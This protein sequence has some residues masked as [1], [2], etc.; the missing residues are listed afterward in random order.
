MEGKKEHLGYLY[1]L[2]YFRSGGSCC[3]LRRLKINAS[4]QSILNGEIKTFRSGWLWK[5][6]DRSE[7]YKTKQKLLD[8]VTEQWIRRNPGKILLKKA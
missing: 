5:W 6:T 7:V 2:T 3:L 8:G 4:S 1:V